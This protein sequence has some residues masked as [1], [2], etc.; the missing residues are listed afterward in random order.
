MI[1][2][3]DLTKRY[4]G[5]TLFEDVQL[6]LNKGQRVGIVGA[7]GSGKSTLLRILSDQEPPP[8]GQV[9]RVKSATVGI[10]DQDHFA[11]ENTPIIDVVMMGN[12]VLWD[13][14]VEKDALLALSLIHI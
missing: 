13:A 7:N 5:Q 12:R 10:L 6:Q 2:V 1:T 14:M 4:G 11:Y 3:N 9:I 8:Q